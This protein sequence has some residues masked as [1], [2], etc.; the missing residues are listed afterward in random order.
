MTEPKSFNRNIDDLVQSIDL[1][2]RNQFLL[3]GLALLYS[4]LDIM[5]WLYQPQS[6]SD[7]RREDFIQWVDK[8]LRPN[9]MLN[10]NAID[11]YAARCS[12]IH[13]YSAE[14]KLSRDGIARRICYTS[15]SKDPGRLQNDLASVNYDA[16]VVHVDTFFNALRSSIDDFRKDLES[17]EDLAKRVF[18]RSETKFYSLLPATGKE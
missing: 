14:S 10:C 6:Q 13:S 18:D 17:N 4:T 15:G 3:P 9:A 16:I 2:F 1:C 12:I 5:A 7:V 8:Y 11:L